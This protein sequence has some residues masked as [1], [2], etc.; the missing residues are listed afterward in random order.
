VLDDEPGIA[1]MMARMLRRDGHTVVALTNP[2]EALAAIERERFDLVVTDLG[3]PA[4]SGWEIAAAAKRR[5]P[6]TRV[7]V[8]TGWGTDLDPDPAASASVDAVLPKPFQF[9]RLRELVRAVLAG[10]PAP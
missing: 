7:V 9:Q 8:A 2:Q 6:T 5:D 4:V 10:E 1:T 3:M